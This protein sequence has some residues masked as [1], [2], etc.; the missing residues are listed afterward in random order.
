MIGAVVLRL[1]LSVHRSLH[2]L[3]VGAGVAEASVVAH[4]A[5]ASAASADAEPPFG[6]FLWLTLGAVL[7]IMAHPVVSP[8]TNSFAESVSTVSFGYGFIAG[9]RLA[10]GN[11]AVATTAEHMGATNVLACV[12]SGGLIIGVTKMMSGYIARCAPRCGTAWLP[13]SHAREQSRASTAIRARAR[14]ARPDR[15][16]PPRAPRVWRPAVLRVRARSAMMRY[17]PTRRLVHALLVGLPL[18]ALLRSCAL[19][20]IPTKG[21]RAARALEA[22]R[23]PLRERDGSPL[24]RARPLAPMHR[25][26]THAGGLVHVHVCSCLLLRSRR[27]HA[28][29]APGVCAEPLAGATAAEGTPATALLRGQQRR[30]ARAGRWRQRGGGDRPVHQLRELWPRAHVGCASGFQRPRAAL[31]TR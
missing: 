3:V 25:A 20:D 2:L 1:W 15:A 29:A 13:A 26:R 24:P 6:F 21:V 27:G 19:V 5:A 17:G 30:R 28:L 11:L 14:R 23:G 12:V 22:R 9:T 10:R 16:P 31:N 18:C 4:G 8:R 7:A